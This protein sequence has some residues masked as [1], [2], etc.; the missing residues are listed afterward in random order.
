MADFPG[1]NIAQ[2]NLSVNSFVL[3]NLAFSLAS[4]LGLIIGIFVADQ[5]SSLPQVTTYN[6][7]P[8]SLS[9]QSFGTHHWDLCGRPTLQ[10][11]TGNY[12]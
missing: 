1:L 6:Y 10:P 3:S 2:S 4:P 7:L 12:I 8:G 5:P 9:G 11:P